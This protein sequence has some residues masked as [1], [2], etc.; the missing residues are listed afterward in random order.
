MLQ[1]ILARP[2]GWLLVLGT[3]TGSAIRATPSQAIAVPS[4]QAQ[5]SDLAP[6][7]PTAQPTQV[8]PTLNQGYPIRRQ[9]APLPI[10]QVYETPIEQFEPPFSD[11]PRDHWAYEAVTRLFYIGGVKGEPTTPTN[12]TQQ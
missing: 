6:T 1:Q 9:D 2:L 7:D 5:T 12:S 11:V 3:L 4:A 10:P 8:D